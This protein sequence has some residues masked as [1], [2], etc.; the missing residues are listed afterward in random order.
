[1]DSGFEVVTMI[2]GL[3]V[4]ES[5]CPE[6]TAPVLSATVN[7]NRNG[8]AVETSGAVPVRVEPLMVSHVGRPAAEKVYAPVPPEAV[9]VW[10]YTSPAVVA[11]KLVVVTAG[12]ALIFN[13]KVLVALTPALSVTFRVKENVPVAGGVPSA[14]HPARSQ[15]KRVAWSRSRRGI[16]RNSARRDDGLRIWLVDGPP[17]QW[18]GR[19]DGHRRVYRDAE[20]FV[21]CEPRTIG[22][23]SR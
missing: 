16:A 2:P 9:R 13:E 11:G 21:A 10:L 12:M 17:W 19:C 22:G 4:M 20:C 23:R 18:R 8:V 7:E 5:V 14:S 6:P 3:T 1:M 15:A